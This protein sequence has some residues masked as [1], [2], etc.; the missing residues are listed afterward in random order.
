MKGDSCCKFRHP[1]F[2]QGH[3]DDMGLI[4]RNVKK[5]RNEALDES[6]ISDHVYDYKNLNKKLLQYK[7]NFDLLLD[8]V[9]QLRGENSMLIKSLAAHERTADSELIPKLLSVVLKIT[10]SSRPELAERVRQELLPI[11][12]TLQEELADC[13]V[14]S[15]DRHR[16][17]NSA[18]K[19]QINFDYLQLL[20]KLLK[21][22]NDTTASQDSTNY[23]R[24]FYEQKNRTSGEDHQRTGELDSSHAPSLEPLPEKGKPPR[25]NISCIYENA[26]NLSHVVSPCHSASFFSRD[27]IFKMDTGCLKSSG[28][29]GAKTYPKTFGV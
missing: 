3:P 1:L 15:T 27:S 28:Q 25:V 6:Q 2:R 20:N 24:C 16:S 21:L 19:V 9:S 7:S 8:Q 18:K 29:S 11:E 26:S 23:H 12:E 13:S 5:Q 17:Q 22:T 4:K 14:L 10:D